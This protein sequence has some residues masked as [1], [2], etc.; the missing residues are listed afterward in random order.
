MLATGRSGAGKTRGAPCAPASAELAKSTP[1]AIHNRARRDLVTVEAAALAQEG[2]AATR[3]LHRQ[4]EHAG[5]LGEG[6]MRRHRDHTH[7]DGPLARCSVTIAM[8]PAGQLRVVQVEGGEAIQ[9]ALGVKGAGQPVAR[10]G[11]R[12]IEAGGVEMTRVDEKP[13]P[14]GRR[15][16]VAEELR[17][18]SYGLAE[19]AA[20]ARVLEEEAR[21][22]RHALHQL[23]ELAR[24]QGERRRGARVTRGVAHVKAHGG[25]ADLCGE[26]EAGQEAR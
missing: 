16:D 26:L 25:E 13:Q 4:L 10:V 2:E 6:G 22:V 20:L 3:V 9:H 12:E 17:N 14:L 21:A 5:Q 7:A 1:S 11:G 23:T 8:G 15:P 24:S 18:L 19:L